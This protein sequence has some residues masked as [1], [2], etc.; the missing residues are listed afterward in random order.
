MLKRI[1]ISYD[2]IRHHRESEWPYGYHL[3]LRFGRESKDEWRKC[4]FLTVLSSEDL[5][6]DR[7]HDVVK[8]W[9]GWQ[10]TGLDTIH[11]WGSNEVRPSRST[12]HR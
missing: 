1:E 12:Q 7:N 9:Q 10:W 6:R 2:L 3:T 8:N 11:Y 4:I 5:P